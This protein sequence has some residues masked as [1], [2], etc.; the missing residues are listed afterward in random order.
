[1]LEPMIAQ[2]VGYLRRFVLAMQQIVVTIK[3][4]ATIVI[5]VLISVLIMPLNI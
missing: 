5:D 4:N 3:Q 2:I 1:M